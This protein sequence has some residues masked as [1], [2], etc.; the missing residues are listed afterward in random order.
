MS[1]K[2]NLEV[3]KLKNS[4][5]KFLILF[6]FILV[7][8][9]SFNAC[10]GTGITDKQRGQP[11][12]PEAGWQDGN[13]DTREFAGQLIKAETQAETER[14]NN[15]VR[16]GSAHLN[17]NNPDKNYTSIHSTGDVY[18][19]ERIRVEIYG[20]REVEEAYVV[21]SGNT[22]IVGYTPAAG[23]ENSRR[24][25]S[26]IADRVREIDEGIRNVAVSQSPDLSARVR[27]LSND[28]GGGRR[29]ESLAGEV[30][31]LVMEI[32]PVTVNR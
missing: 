13:T 21:V 25:E 9:F 20:M 18:R 4:F 2:K 1:E 5:N 6:T 7:C 28:Q 26:L 23:F 31:R 24:I 16:G 15:Q 10:A 11:V 27:E 8:M 14:E 30:D 22:C 19:A 3:Q 32:N 17:T 12:Q 29:I